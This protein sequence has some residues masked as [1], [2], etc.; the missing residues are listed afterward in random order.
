MNGNR[1]G[2]HRD[3]EPSEAARRRDA[4]GVRLGFPTGRH[5]WRVVGSVPDLRREGVSELARGFV[6]EL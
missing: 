2:T 3:P 5:D 4:M 6:P 1:G